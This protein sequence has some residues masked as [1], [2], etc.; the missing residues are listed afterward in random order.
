MNLNSL[1]V[2]PFTKTIKYFLKK[3]LNYSLYAFVSPLKCIIISSND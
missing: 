2:K 3:N 1:E